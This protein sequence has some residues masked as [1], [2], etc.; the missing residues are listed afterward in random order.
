MIRRLKANVF[1]SAGLCMPS[2]HRLWTAA[3]PF[4]PYLHRDNNMS[5]ERQA[6][7]RQL[8]VAC[9]STL[10]LRTTKAEQGKAGIVLHLMVYS[11]E[12][13]RMMVAEPQVFL[14]E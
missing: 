13:L 14:N 5:F 1:A 8:Q 3:A 12:Y 10:L 6:S 2:L 11:T 4:L 9:G 7:R